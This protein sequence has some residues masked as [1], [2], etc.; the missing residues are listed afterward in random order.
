MNIQSCWPTKDIGTYLLKLTYLRKACGWEFQVTYM[1]WRKLCPLVHNW[2]HF[3]IIKSIDQE[4]PF[5]NS[6]FLKTELVT[7]TLEILIAKHFLHAT[8]ILPFM[9]HLCF[10]SVIKQLPIWCHPRR[11]LQYGVRSVVPFA[12]TTA[13]R[14]RSVACADPALVPNWKT[15][16]WRPIENTCIRATSGDFTLQLW[17]V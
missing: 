11:T 5:S 9:I 10:L 6:W 14:A 13:R 1:K 16:C 3:L 8:M 7:I 12:R 4:A 15:A 2:I 17:L